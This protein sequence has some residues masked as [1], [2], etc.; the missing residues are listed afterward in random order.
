MERKTKVHA[1]EGKQEILI[2][3]RFVNPVQKVEGKAVCSNLWASAC[4][5]WHHV[6]QR[7]DSLLVEIG[8]VNRA[9]GYGANVV[10]GNEERVDRIDNLIES[11]VR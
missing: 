1:E 11:F 5:G 7:E 6:H 3:L 4:P 9:N 8:V 10:A 2:T